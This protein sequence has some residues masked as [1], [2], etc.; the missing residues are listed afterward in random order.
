ME[1]N[2]LPDSFAAGNTVTYRKRYADYPVSG[3]T[4]MLIVNGVSGKKEFPATVDGDDF[5]FTLPASGASPTTGDLAAGLYKWVE[6]VTAT[7]GTPAEVQ[8]VD[9]G[10]VTVTLNLATA[11]AAQTQLPQER[12]IALLWARIEGRLQP[13]AD[14]E[15]QQLLGRAVSKIPL[16]ECHR[17]IRQMETELLKLRNPS[18]FGTPVYFTLS[19]PK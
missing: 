3:W 11:T 6:R 16:A 19:R 9:S 17:L 1:L 2:A 4:A 8:D 10:N 5:V 18:E 7:T 12:C 15:S 14:N 13:G